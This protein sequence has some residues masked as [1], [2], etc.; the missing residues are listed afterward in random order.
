ME[1]INKYNRKEMEE[2]LPGYIFGELSDLDK[3]IFEQSLSDY[4]DIQD[5]IQ[6]VRHTFELLD[7]IDYDKVLFDKTKDIPSRVAREVAKSNST[8][9]QSFISFRFLVPAL[10][11]AGLLFVVVKTGFINNYWN[12]LKPKT[13]NM[14]SQNIKIDS[15][16]SEIIADTQVQN[17]IA[18]SSEFDNPHIFTIEEDD[19]DQQIKNY[20]EQFMFGINSYFNTTNSPNIESYLTINTNIENIDEEIFEQIIEDIKNANL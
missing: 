20:Y 7:K 8:K 3:E 17:E 2:R 14:I 12:D 19:F 16:V 18:Q 15:A 9:K 11:T 4:P 13:N 6:Q 5:E 10:I 1:E